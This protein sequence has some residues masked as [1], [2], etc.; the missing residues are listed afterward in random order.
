M[1]AYEEADEK[2]EKVQQQPVVQHVQQVVQHVEEEETCSLHALHALSPRAQPPDVR[3]RPP[4]PPRKES[5]ESSVKH[6]VVREDR[7]GGGWARRPSEAIFDATILT[8]NE[9]AELMHILPVLSLHASA[10]SGYA[11]YT[12]YCESVSE[13]V[14]TS[15]YDSV[16]SAA[17]VAGAGRAE[18]EREWFN[19]TADVRDLNPIPQSLA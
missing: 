12:D 5:E 13:K 10:P 2:S 8:R 1:R 4:P 11:R 14:S 17:T 15:C 18:R 19:V 6:G 7:G 9:A 16:S 3:T